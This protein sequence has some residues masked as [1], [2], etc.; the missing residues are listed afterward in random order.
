ML[1]CHFPDE[2]SY[3]SDY[4]IDIKKD[5]ITTILVLKTKNKIDFVII[6]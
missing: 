6:K 2:I 4:E 1:G 5:V 3:I